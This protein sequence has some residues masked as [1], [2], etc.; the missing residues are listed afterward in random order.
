MDA[1]PGGD[2]T[3]PPWIEWMNSTSQWNIRNFTHRKNSEVENT[4]FKMWLLGM[5]KLKNAK[6]TPTL[7][8]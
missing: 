6:K 3:M 8:T 2:Q 7:F 5:L 1:G 4:D